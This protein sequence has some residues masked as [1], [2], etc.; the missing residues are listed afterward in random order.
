MSVIKPLTTQNIDV[1]VIE[2]QGIT[3]HEPT[4]ESMKQALS[5]A[6]AYQ[7]ALMRLG[8]ETRVKK[9]AALGELWTQRNTS[10]AWDTVKDLLASSTGYSRSLIDEEFKLVAEVFSREN[11]W[12]ILE[13]GLMGGLGS[14]DGFK[15]ISDNESVRNMPIGPMLII[16]SGNS[17]IPPLIPTVIGL[18]TGNFV[19]LK[20]SLSNVAGLNMIFGLLDEIEGSEPLRDC[21]FIA[22]LGHES[23]ALD[24]LLREAPLGVVN[25]W[26]AQPAMGIVGAKVGENRHHPRYLVNGPLTGYVVVKEEH[27]DEAVQGVALNIVLYDQQ[28]CS[29]PTQSAFIGSKE[30][31]DGFVKKLGESL[32]FVGGAQPINVSEGGNYML[33]GVRRAL[34]M[35][36]SKVVSS[37]DQSNPWTVVVSE[38][39]SKLGE[40]VSVFPQFNLYNRKRFMEII[41]VD[42]FSEA[43]DL[44]S[45]LPDNPGW[46]GVEKVQTIG[47]VE[48]NEDEY[49]LL[50]ETGAYRIVSLDD[51]YMRSPSEPYD[52]VSLPDAFTYKVYRRR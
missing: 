6:S 31:L 22:Y 30:A 45:V 51:M 9:L 32:N 29:S 2:A 3:F 52:G 5:N 39:T 40:A 21:L 48:L 23:E 13:Q 16:S 35:K 4:A 18:L 12:A 50:A 28:L 15:D 43:V 38:G 20:P 17:V 25:F 37:K 46:A 24:Y 11:L 19:V 47:A 49:N 41:R 27:M 10:G 33:Q 7:K 14:L 36:G 26:G 1:K 8:A 42:D 34:M 44:I